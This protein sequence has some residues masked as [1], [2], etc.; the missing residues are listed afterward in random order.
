[1][2]WQRAGHNLG[3]NSRDS[4]DT[5]IHSSSG[6]HACCFHVLAIIHRAAVSWGASLFEIHVFSVCIEFYEI[7]HKYL[8]LSREFRIKLQWKIL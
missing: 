5:F 6:A 2:G 4:K 1:M 8:I 7:C 3:P